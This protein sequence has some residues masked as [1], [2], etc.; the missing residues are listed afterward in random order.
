M[1]IRNIIKAMIIALLMTYSTSAFSANETVSSQSFTPTY[2]MVSIAKLLDRISFYSE[3][4]KGA[5]STAT[6]FCDNLFIDAPK[7][8]DTGKSPSSYMGNYGLPFQISFLD[9]W[10]ILRGFFAAQIAEF[11]TDKDVLGDQTILLAG[12]LGFQ[13]KNYFM[14][15]VGY[16][17]GVKG[18][19]KDTSG[20]VLQTGVPLAYLYASF[21]FANNEDLLARSITEFTLSN[22]EIRELIWQRINLKVLKVLYFPHLGFETVKRNLYLADKDGRYYSLYF[23]D[24]SLLGFAYI[25]KGWDNE[26]WMIGIPFSAR[27]GLKNIFGSYY[28]VGLSNIMDWSSGR[29]ELS[30]GLPTLEIGQIY[31][32][33]DYG[34]TLGYSVGAHFIFKWLGEEGGKRFGGYDGTFILVQ[35]SYNVDFPRM[36]WQNKDTLGKKSYNFDISLGYAW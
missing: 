23:E 32:F 27:I 20:F 36:L 25:D 12:G 21:N 6:V 1:L 35:G 3:A 7:N 2:K 15:N 30:I 19:K 14:A 16:I 22:K 10:L 26:V 28:T 24:K 9:Q 33:Y 5:N 31:D 34:M 8:P 13:I 11:L 17:H 29:Y 18:D 4:L